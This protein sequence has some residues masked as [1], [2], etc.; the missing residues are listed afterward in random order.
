M[1]IADPGGLQLGRYI[2]ALVLVIGLILVLGWALRRWRLPG[3]AAMTDRTTRLQI[4]QSKVIDP[5]TRLMIVACDGR[6]HLL[7]LGTS[8]CTPLGPISESVPVDPDGDA[9]SRGPSA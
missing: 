4:V 6:E 3:F 1:S 2:V 7:V 8:Y 9:A 5:R